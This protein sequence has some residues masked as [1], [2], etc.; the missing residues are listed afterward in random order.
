MIIRRAVEDD[1]ARLEAMLSRCT[2]ETRYR[3]FHG[4]LQEFPEPYFTEALKGPPHHFALV[5][6]T[7]GKIVALASCASG[8][9]GILV[10]DSYQRQ[11]IGTR[12]LK[13]LVAE[14]GHNEFSASVQPDQRW[15]VPVLLR[16]SQIKIE[17]S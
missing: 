1:H 10:E 5:A 15:I 9:L 6:E 8:E 16:H 2:R 13:T 4:F 14:S 17:I 11:G 7:H 3:R 12:L